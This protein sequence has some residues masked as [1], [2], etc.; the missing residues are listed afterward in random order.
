MERRTADSKDSRSSFRTSP[1]LEIFDHFVSRD[2]VIQET[3]HQVGRLHIE[4]LF[5]YLTVVDHCRSLVVCLNL[6]SRQGARL[7]QRALADVFEIQPA[8]LVGDLLPPHKRLAQSQAPGR[9]DPAL[10]SESFANLSD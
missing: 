10:A 8:M 3:V 1:D 2:R 9:P 6:I 7:V 4:Y 5:I